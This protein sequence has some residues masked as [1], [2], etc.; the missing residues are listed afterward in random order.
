MEI[1]TNVEELGMRSD[2]VFDVRK[3]SELVRKTNLT[4]KT[5]IKEHNLTSLSAP[6]IG[7]YK[8]MFVINFNGDLRCY[9]NPM[10]V[11]KKGLY[12]SKEKCSS[13]PGKLYIRPRNT[14][15]TACYLTPLGKIE[16]KRFTGMAASVFQHE[17][18]HLDGLLLCDVG[19]EIDERFEKA[20]TDEQAEVI[21]AYIESLDLKAK[22]VKK[23][24]EEDKELSELYE[25]IDLME[26]VAKG[27]VKLT[28]GKVKVQEES[29]E[30]EDEH[31][32][33]QTERK[34]S[35]SSKKNRKH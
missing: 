32:N 18:D 7:V 8:R 3:E 22:E 2:E 34:T 14:E 12:I 4:L 30:K 24:I 29:E 17:V 16:T 15:I 20:S 26:E 23:E 33:E 21:K 9:I 35:V 27:N 1:I 6:A 5:L 10:I 19:L 31:D 11:G 13:L 28:A 25:A